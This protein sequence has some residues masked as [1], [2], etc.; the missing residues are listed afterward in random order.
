[1]ASRN[2]F[3]VFKKFFLKKGRN[4]SEKAADEKQLDFGGKLLQDSSLQ[5]ED[6]YIRFLFD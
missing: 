5:I 1:M 4:D 3:T 2:F 6:M